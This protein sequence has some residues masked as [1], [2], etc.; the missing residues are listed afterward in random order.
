[1][2]VF[3]SAFNR[4]NNGLKR[5]LKEVC[6]PFLGWLALLRLFCPGATSLGALSASQNGLLLTSR[7]SVLLRRALF[8]LCLLFGPSYLSAM[9]Y[10]PFYEAENAIPSLKELLLSFTLSL[11]SDTLAE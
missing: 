6:D 9:R 1:M 5:S 3:L 4:V 10:G 2:L 8:V 11:S 7:P